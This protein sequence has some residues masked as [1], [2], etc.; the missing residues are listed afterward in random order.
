[1]GNVAGVEASLR[2]APL[3]LKSVTSTNVA[4]LNLK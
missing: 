4:R 1:V 2:D 3:D